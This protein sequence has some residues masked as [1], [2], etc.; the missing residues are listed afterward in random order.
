MAFRNIAV[1]GSTG[2]L[3][4]AVVNALVDAGFAV[5]ALSQSGKTQNLPSQV[6]T[7]KVDYSSQ[8]SIIHALKGQDAFVS[9]IPKHEDQ[10]ALIDAAIAAGVK[11]F[12]PSEFGS[13]IAGSQKVAGLPVFAGKKKTQD[14]LKTKEDKISYAL[15]VN[16]L[17]LDWGL[18]VGFWA[19]FKGATRV[20]DGGNEKHSTT[21]LADVGKTVAA[22]LKKPEDFKNRPVYVQSAAVSQNQLLE[23]AQKKKPELKLERQEVS[24]A[25]VEKDAY[26][27]LGKGDFSSMISFVIVSI[28]NSSYSNNW[29]QKNDNELLG[30]KEKSPQE[31]EQIVEQYL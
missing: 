26:E 11:F 8:D 18:Q 6:K 28:F 17:F 2:N 3:G 22:I 5:A 4:P 15:V 1:A 31:L 19:N 9:L 27:K 29:S 25:D 21:T 14:Y 10:P 16:G 7:V 13:D 20:F 23:I 12:I 30:I 24:T